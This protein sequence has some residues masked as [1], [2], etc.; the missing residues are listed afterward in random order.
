MEKS[1][2]IKWITVYIVRRNSSPKR[3]VCLFIFEIKLPHKKIQKN[4]TL[5]TLQRY[6][7]FFSLWPEEG[8]N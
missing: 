3:Y 5:V 6:E 4:T 8:M 7:K 2:I 1:E